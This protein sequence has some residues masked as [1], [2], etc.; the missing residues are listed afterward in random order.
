MKENN[1]NG[2]CMYCGR[3]MI[4][5]P[6]N[7]NKNIDIIPQQT[8]VIECTSCN[9]KLLILC[10]VEVVCCFCYSD[11]LVGCS[12][13][14]GNSNYLLCSNPECPDWKILNKRIISSYGSILVNS[15]RD[16]IINNLVTNYKIK[17][18]I[19]NNHVK[20]LGIIQKIIQ[21]KEEKSSIQID[22]KYF[23]RS[24]K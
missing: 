8:D 24:K 2:I 19:L 4:R 15:P 23:N 6:Y 9:A 22:L 1:K 18:G 11:L 16:I 10:G 17:T 3:T 13:L 12:D 20:V 21:T 5:Y 7:S 14:N